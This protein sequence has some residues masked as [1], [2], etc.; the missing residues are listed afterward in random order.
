MIDPG[1]RDRRI[2]F[3]RRE[4]TERTAKGEAVFAYVEFTKAWASKK[5]VSDRE[6]MLAQQV[7]ATVSTRFVTLWNALLDQV[8]PTFR[9]RF[10]GRIYEITGVK[11][12]GTREGIEFTTSAKADIPKEPS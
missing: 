1:R 12:I 2:T 6:R 7:S 10:G 8:D 3:E 5:D 11:E 4:Q 9:I